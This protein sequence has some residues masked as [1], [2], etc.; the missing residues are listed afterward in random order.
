MDIDSFKLGYRQLGT[1]FLSDTKSV[2]G[3]ALV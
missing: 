3:A 1:K 2:N